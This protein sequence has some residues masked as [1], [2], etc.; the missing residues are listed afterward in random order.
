MELQVAYMSYII[1]EA[2]TDEFMMRNFGAVIEID[3]DIDQKKIDFFDSFDD[4]REFVKLLDTLFVTA[5]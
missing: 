4:I 2:P 5:G 1:G 3:I